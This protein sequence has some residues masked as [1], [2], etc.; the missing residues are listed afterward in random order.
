MNRRN[1][2]L[3]SAAGAFGAVFAG[4]SA[5]QNPQE[6]VLEKKLTPFETEVNIPKPSGGTMPL[7]RIGKTDI[8][9]SKFGFGSHIWKEYIHH[10]KEREWMVREAHDLGVTLFDVYDKEQECF[11]YEPMGKYLKPII[12]DVVI[13]I[14]VLPYDGRNLKQEFERDL[15]LFGRD[16][17][18][19]VRIHAHNEKHPHWKYWDALFRYKEQGKI[20]AIGVPIH[21]WEHLDV[22]LDA[23]PL[24]YVIFPYNFY[25]NICWLEEPPD[26]FVSLPAKLR[27]RG[28]GV[29]SMKPFAGDYLAIPF[30]EMAAKLPGYRDVNFPQAALRYIINSGLDPDTTLTG[31]YSPYHVYEN[32]ATYFNPQMSDDE[33]GLLNTLRGV[34]KVSAQ[35]LLPPHYKWL[36]K[37]AVESRA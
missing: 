12:N 24:D 8:I 6:I 28:I 10:T 11:Q 4:C 18:D 35:A 37:W 34:A 32:I 7:G 20:R 29:V 2:L 14:A 15:R 3:Q 5:Q 16:H 9:V 30:K 26:D 27:A 33:R 25:H 36:G 22:L 21:D 1:F 31:M 17:I 23:Y 13:S 19:M